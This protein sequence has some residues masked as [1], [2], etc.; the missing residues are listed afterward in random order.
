MRVVSETAKP[1]GPGSS[2]RGGLLESQDE[3]G[4]PLR[5][6]LQIATERLKLNPGDTDALFAMAA[7]QAT[8]DDAK[9]GLQTLDRLAD[10][11]SAGP[12]L[13][14]LKKEIH[15]KPGPGERPPER[16]R[17]PPQ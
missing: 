11:E 9:G 5:L 2:S 7:A 12:R 15:A 4:Q 14:G 3:R 17:R 8:L 16:R 13:W 10:P 1:A 6:I